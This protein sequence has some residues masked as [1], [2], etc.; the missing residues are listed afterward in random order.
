MCL[1]LVAVLAGGYR[2][3]NRTESQG[4]HGTRVALAGAIGILITYNYFALGLPGA[5][6]AYDSLG[7]LAAPVWAVLGGVVGLTA[8]LFWFV[9]R[10]R[11]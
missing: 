5:R 2:L 9:Y 6:L 7:A 11:A 10:P 4:R 3:G 8:G 1:G